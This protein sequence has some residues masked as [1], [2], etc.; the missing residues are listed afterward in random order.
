MSL[1]GTIGK[2]SLGFTGDLL[3]NLT[4]LAES[5]RPI[6]LAK[7]TKTQLPRLHIPNINASQ[8]INNSVLKLSSRKE[9]S[10]NLKQKLI[11]K[12]RKTATPKI[13]AKDYLI[14]R[15]KI[16]RVMQQRQITPFGTLKIA[17]PIS[18][19]IDAVSENPSKVLA[20]LA[21]GTTAVGIGS[22]LGGLAYSKYKQHQAYKQMF[23][24]FPEFNDVPR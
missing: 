17:G 13:S 15:I 23:K 8:L 5:F 3:S 22:E 7:A 6:T 18:S 9:T 1:L 19:V 16:A 24:E 21:L 12:M 14:N 10:M 11:S 4:P 20:G 2:K